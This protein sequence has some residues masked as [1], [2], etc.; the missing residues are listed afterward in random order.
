MKPIPLAILLMCIPGVTAAL[1]C[2]RSGDR[3]QD[4]DSTSPSDSIDLVVAL[5]DG[6]SICED[7]DRVGPF[8]FD[9]ASIGIVDCLT[10][11]GAALVGSWS[12]DDAGSHPFEWEADAR[13]GGFFP[14]RGHVGV[15]V[16]CGDEHPQVHSPDVGVALDPDGFAWARLDV[17]DV[18]IPIGGKATLDGRFGATASLDNPGVPSPRITVTTTGPEAP[19]TSRGG[20]GPGDTFLWGVARA[21]LVRVVPAREGLL[22]PI[23]WVEIA[24]SDPTTHAADR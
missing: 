8:R 14:T 17:G 22:G 20:L 4:A 16:G 5:C 3:R 18:F 9:G 2:R 15:E 11:G 21:R 23:G 1:G 12:L 10:N 24:L 13:L 7:F 19:Q 6:A